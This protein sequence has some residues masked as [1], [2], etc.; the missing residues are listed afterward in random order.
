MSWTPESAQADG[1]RRLSESLADV[2]SFSETMRAMAAHVA[3]ESGRWAPLISHGTLSF[4]EKYAGRLDGL[5]EEGALAVRRRVDT[6]SFVTIANQYALRM[7]G[8]DGKVVQETIPQMYMRVA[9]GCVT[10]PESDYRAIC[11]D[12]SE[13][14]E[15][16]ERYYM[17]LVAGEIS[18]AT[19]QMNSAGTPRFQGASCFLVELEED[20]MLGICNTERDVALIS[21]AGGGVG[22]NIHALRGS[23]SYIH[24]THGFSNGVVPMLRKFNATVRYADQGGG[25]RKGG[26]AVYLE[27][28]HKDI[29]EFLQLQ[30]NQGAEELRA[31]DIFVAVW[32]RDAFFK[33][34]A[35]GDP[36]HLFCPTR[37]PEMASAASAAEFEAAYARYAAAGVASDTISARELLYQICETETD[38]GGPYI[39]AADNVNRKSNQCNIGPVKMSNLC[40]EIVQFTDPEHT[41]VCN[42]STLAVPAF[43]REERADGTRV[44]RAA[45]EP[46]RGSIPPAGVVRRVFDYEAL[47]DRVRMV[48]RTL[49]TVI[50][51]STYPT[52]KA[53]RSNMRTRPL[54]I[55]AQGVATALTLLGLPYDSDQALAAEACIYES[56][57]YAALDESANLAAERGR[58]EAFEGSPFA[59]G[60]FQFDLWDAEEAACGRKPLHKP[61][62]TLDWDTL[63]AKVKRLGTRHSLLTASPPTATSAKALGNEE[64]FRPVERHMQR[65]DTKSGEFVYAN[66]D[67]FADAR[68]CGV[69]AGKL[70]E[71]LIADDGGTRFAHELPGTDAERTA[72]WVKALEC[73]KTILEISRSG[74]LK[75]SVARGHFTDQSQSLNSYFNTPVSQLAP[76]KMANYY[77]AAWK[78]GLKTISYYSKFRREAEPLKFTAAGIDEAPAC[79]S[80]GE[81]TA[82]QS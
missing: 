21:K 31:R 55:G 47:R 74:W 75:H 52:D 2:Q 44:P 76:D 32:A 24:G 20:S 56:I 11:T 69:D 42:L 65:Y 36:W 73:H 81:C 5:V 30:R 80:R 16:V 23:G 18:P 33:A 4:V 46:L 27:V 78:A 45:G 39:L 58:Y 48:V 59:A 10:P 34:A 77:I 1:R 19:P 38:T 49:D 3:P 60:R 15:R 25:K 66:P 79:R 35:A 40:A 72:R 26:L 53:Q 22:L 6:L 9:V 50:D 57:Y 71:A 64:G 12:S 54:G 14:L 37:V 82:C 41:A 67:I 8:A 61:A 13:L 63:R 51:K 68:T 70:R 29:R 43:V 62:L 7:Q 17:A 28:W